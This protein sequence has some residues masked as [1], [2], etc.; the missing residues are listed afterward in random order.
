ML[1]A[2]VRLLIAAACG[3]LML[4]LPFGRTETGATLRRW[5]GV[6]FVLAFLPSI[7][8]SLF[9][10]PAQSTRSTAGSTT[11]T[12]SALTNVLADLGCI[13]LLVLFAL[14]AYGVL[15]LRRRFT[16]KAAPLDPWER[17]FQRGGGK[18][19]FT[20]PRRD[21]RSPRPFFIRDEG[22]D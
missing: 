7:L 16:R 11:A 1:F 6:C 10:L 21:T 15:K 20:G 22:D 3:F 17:F 8:S 9:F 5:A 13:T 14:V 19:P 4:S 12:T 18:R 2:V